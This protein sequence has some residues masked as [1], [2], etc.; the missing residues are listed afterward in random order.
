MRA[1]PATSAERTRQTEMTWA[2]GGCRLG[3]ASVEVVV[4]APW[5]DPLVEVDAEAEAFM[6]TPSSAIVGIVR[7]KFFAPIAFLQMV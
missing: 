3:A 5:C 7:V 1:E 2:M 6:L 4:V